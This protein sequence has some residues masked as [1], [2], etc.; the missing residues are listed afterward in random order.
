MPR[1]DPNPFPQSSGYLY[2]W[3]GR[4]RRMA[5]AEIDL[6]RWFVDRFPTNYDRVWFDTMIPSNPLSPQPSAVCPAGITDKWS[7]CW[8]CL[9]CLRADV[10]ARG[11]KPPPD[12]NTPFSNPDWPGPHKLPMYHQVIE[13]RSNPRF[14]T[15]LQSIHITSL[16][17]H[18]YPNH[19]WRPPMVIC[20][21][22]PL[23]IK[24]TDGLEVITLI[25][26]ADYDR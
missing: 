11:I 24:L 7:W 1:G 25:Q 4:P 18:R 8:Q 23:H 17:I 15:L 2:H 5:H 6:W 3:P 20:D 14:Q 16:Y 13:I 9:T 12:R 26:R 10:L 22:L 19:K 21:S